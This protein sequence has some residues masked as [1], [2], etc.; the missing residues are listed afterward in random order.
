[1]HF[2]AGKKSINRSGK[3]HSGLARQEISKIYACCLGSMR[4]KITSLTVLPVQSY[5][6]KAFSTY[7]YKKIK[8]CMCLAGP[9]RE[10]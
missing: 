8:E 1:M 2:L 6:T 5:T 3:C 10:I 9:P 4:R 7:S